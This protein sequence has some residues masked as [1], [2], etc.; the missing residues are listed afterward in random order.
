MGGRGPG[1]AAEQFPLLHAVEADNSKEQAAT[2]EQRI[3]AVVDKMEQIIPRIQ[4]D[5]GVTDKQVGTKI[6]RIA[7]SA[8]PEDP[9]SEKLTIVVRSRGRKPTFTIEAELRDGTDVKVLRAYHM[10]NTEFINPKNP[11]ITRTDTPHV[12]FTAHELRPDQHDGVDACYMENA[13]G[14]LKYCAEDYPFV[15]PDRIA[16]AT[17][18]DGVN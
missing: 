18:P 12:I 17:G 9:R 1:S 5:Q 11:R 16:R 4:V 13:F 2:P 14:I 6:V 7:R 8:I 3:A 10:S 15:H